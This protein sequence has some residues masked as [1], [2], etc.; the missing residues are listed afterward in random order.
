MILLDSS[1]L[2]D[3]FRS[4]NKEKTL[5]YHLASAENDF[6][7]SII[8][9]YEIYAGSNERQDPFWKALIQSIE[10]LD[11]DLQSS[12]QAVKIYKH[13]KKTNKMIDLADILIAATSI[14]NN[15]PLATL[16]LNHF[17]RI[18]GLEIVKK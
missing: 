14:S 17:E 4:S 12:V 18:K 11:F 3:L 1:I 16:N 10:I 7:I 8:T 6:A 13:L 15:I 2:I 5:F 9:H